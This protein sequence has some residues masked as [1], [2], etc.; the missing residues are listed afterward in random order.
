MLS[1]LACGVHAHEPQPDFVGLPSTGRLDA[2]RVLESRHGANAPQEDDKAAHK[3]PADKA[4]PRKD[5]AKHAPERERPEAPAPA[6]AFAIPA[7]GITGVV[8]QG[9]GRAD[10]SDVPLSFGQVFAPGDLPRGAGLAGKLAD[11]TLLPLQLDVKA[12]HPDG[13]VRH[14]V[15]SAIL[16]RLGAGKEL[17]LALVKSARKTDKAD[18]ADAAKPGSAPDTVVT[19]VVDGE[20][21]S[22]SSAALLKARKAQVWLQ[23]PIVTELQVAAPLVDAQGEEHPHLAA[24]F[25]VRTYG[26]A[27]QARVDVVVE[28]NWAY[29]PD[30]RNIT[31]DVTIAAGGKQ[32][33]ARQGLTHLHHARWRALAWTGEAPALHLRHDTA[34]LIGSRALPNYD[35]SVVVHDAALAALAAKWNGANT[36]PMGVGLAAR[37]MPGPGG[38]PD[39][40]LLPGWAAAYLLSMDARAKQVTLGTADLAGSWPIHYRDKQTGLPVSLID[41]PYMT[42]LGR[43][44]DT[45]NRK[46][47]KSEA[48]P[49]CP[50]SA[51]K[52]PNT[53]DSSHQPGLAY[54]PYLVTGDHYYLEELQFWAMHNVFESNPGYRKNIQGLFAPGQVRGQAWNLRTLGQAAYITPDSHPLKRHFATI[55]DSN[56]AW[57][58]AA[59]SHNPDANKLG[60][61]A[62]GYAVVYKGKTAVAP[63]QDD[64]FTAAVGHLAELGFKDAEPLLKWKA[65]FPVQRMVGEGAC[66]IAGANY[67]Y[68]VRAAPNAPYFESI[69][70]AYAAT[71]GPE[72]AALPCASDQLAAGLK[73]KP[74]DM[75][76][77]AAEPTG[78]PSN[79][80]PALAYAASVGG[81]AGRKAWALFKARSVQPDYGKSPQFAIVP[82]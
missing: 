25:A 60:I 37:T 82:R 34:Y 72:L 61:I 21:F 69:A 68:A 65:R 5:A 42:I 1:A 24:R 67:T 79:M 55:L 54:L 76:G 75:G 29:E 66:W 59:Y 49:R 28:N 74:G 78:F 73:R 81:E 16:P 62:H 35:R 80:Q 20:R 13:S 26:G 46:S 23:G 39:I 30:P 38:R 19:V 17:G 50:K 44:G 56:L 31:Y 4:R 70:D 48:F 40:G 53:P 64:F 22:A 45:R 6:R 36:E 15:V 77:Y 57:Y 63:W 3:E 11:G 8:V 12:S 18:N 47:G 10:Q 33:Y 41:Y 2:S 14:A 58:N 51:C 52:S 32:V 43:P 9:T 71:V 27:R 7:G